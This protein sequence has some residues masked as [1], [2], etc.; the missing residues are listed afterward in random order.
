MAPASWGDA[1]RDTLIFLTNPPACRVYHSAAT[2]IGTGVHTPLAFNS[3]RYDTDTMH[4]TAVSNTRITI[5]TA[6]VYVVTFNA[7]FAAN[8]TGVRTVGIRINGAS[9][10]ALNAAP[11]DGAVNPVPVTVATEYKFAA[12]NYIEATAWQ[13]SGGN[14]NVNSTN[15]SP[16]FSATWIGLG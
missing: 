13:D 4:D 9:F 12:G 6:G 14:L 7:E 1:V 8:A 10:L 11:A 5:T 2:L 16:E 15:Y 3:E